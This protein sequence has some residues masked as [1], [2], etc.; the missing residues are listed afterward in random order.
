[1]TSPTSGFTASR[2]TVE[3]LE[4]GIQAAIS[5][6]GLLNPVTFEAERDASLRRTLLV[7]RTSIAA[8][9]EQTVWV[10]GERTVPASWWQA[11][12]QEVLVPRLPRRLARKGA[13]KTRMLHISGTDTY[14]SRTCPHV[15]LPA[16]DKA[17]LL[18]LG[19]QP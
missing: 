2:F 16:G 14:H 8:G 3:S 6:L 13:V 7:L 19:G 4:V 17:H 1:M 10:N 9:C 12:K 15:T 5:D 18:F 11:W